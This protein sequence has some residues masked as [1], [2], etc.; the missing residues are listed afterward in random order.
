[1]CMCVLHTALI[2]T[3]SGNKL[4]AGACVSE[5][6]VNGDAVWQAASH[7]H[8]GSRCDIGVLESKDAEMHTMHRRTKHDIKKAAK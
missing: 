3:K 6:Q 1:M 2:I 5:H 4:L 7:G 8:S